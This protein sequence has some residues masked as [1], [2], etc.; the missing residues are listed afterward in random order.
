MLSDEISLYQLRLALLV[1]YFLYAMHG[2]EG[3][4]SD[5]SIRLVL[6]CLF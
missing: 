1:E 6:L 2:P 4:Y 3:M 5:Y